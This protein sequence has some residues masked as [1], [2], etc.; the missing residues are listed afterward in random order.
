MEDKTYQRSYESFQDAIKQ[1]ASCMDDY[2]FVFDLKKDCYYISSSAAER[3]RMP[4]NE[5]SNASEV[6]RG[7]VYSEDYQML[8]NDLANLTS[9]KKQSHNLRYRWLGKDGSPIWINCRGIVVKDPDSV[10]EFMIGCVNEIGVKQIADNVS[11]LLGESAF[12]N[13][14][15]R[16][17]KTF[18]KGFI[19]RIGIDDFR[20]INEKF[21]TEYGDIILR[22]VAEC[23]EHSLLPGQQAYRMV[24]DE[25]VVTDFLGGSGSDAEK[26]YFRIC[27]EIE[28]KIEERHYESVYTISGGIIT[29]IDITD[30]DYTDITK[31]SHFALGEAKLRGKNQVYLFR[32]EDYS[33]FLRKRVL[34]RA[35]HE[36]VANNFHGFEL[37]FQPI[38]KT[39]SAELFAAEALLRFRIYDTEFV[40]P[41]EFIPI[42][43]ESGLII[44]VGKW[45]LHRAMSMCQE[46]QK[47][48]PDFKISI[49]LSYIQIIKSAILTEITSS[50]ANATLRPSSIIMELTESGHLENTP[51]IQNVWNRLK[52]HGVNIAIDDFGTGYSNLQNIG[53]LM[54]HIV[55][56]DRNFTAKALQNAYEYQLMI[57]I[58]QMVHSLGLQ[59]C[60]EG[61]ETTEEL[62]KISALNPDFIQGYYYSRPCPK[63]EFIE[64]FPS[65]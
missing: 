30:L 14:I 24:A 18:P 50:I 5:F 10:P 12:R 27:G 29:S 8:S 7:F 26:L 44:P 48:Y 55:K 35:L 40:A 61:I 46:C 19:L 17:R 39:G 45:I 1:F 43:E 22:I 2:L 60:V 63:E 4:S 11:G 56:L 6:L 13:Q 37:Y 16:F 53:T 42:L 33:R 59:V 54:P 64:K 62:V 38:M 31:I 32:T 58:I 23:I 52:E 25:F 20:D 65:K 36:A 3:F 15:Q 21:G 28:E 51:A 57:N 34:L 9:G 49:N 47:Q 41:I